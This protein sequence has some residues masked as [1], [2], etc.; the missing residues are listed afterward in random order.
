MATV[1]VPRQ[2]LDDTDPVGGREARRDLRGDLV[3]AGRIGDG[4]APSPST[5]PA[6]GRADGDTGGPW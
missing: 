2:L 6:S 3:L 4:P 5:V 1:V